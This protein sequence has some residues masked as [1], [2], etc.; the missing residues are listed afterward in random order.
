MSGVPETSM[1]LQDRL[2]EALTPLGGELRIDAFIALL[3]RERART[4]AS[5]KVARQAARE[6]EEEPAPPPRAARPAPEPK[7][8][9]DL[10]DEVKAFLNRDEIQEAGDE[11]VSDFMDFMGDTGFNPD[12]M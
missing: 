4:A 2:R 6:A 11:E 3:A 7:E 12:T 8:A 1:S 9:V 5:Q 10:E